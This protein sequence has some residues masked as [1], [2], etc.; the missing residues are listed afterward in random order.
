M[1]DALC[2]AREAEPT[3]PPAHI[4]SAFAADGPLT[5]LAGGRGVA[6]RAGSIVLKPAASSEEALGWQA[7][8]L[9]EISDDHLRLAL[10]RRSVFGTFLFGGWMAAVF[11]IGAHEPRRWLDIIAAG[12]RLHAAL[13]NVACPGFESARHD[14][15]SIADQAA[16]GEIPLS[17]YLDA[18]H[19][20]RLA[21]RLVPVSAP[22]QVIHG[23]LTGNVL[24]ADPLPPAVIDLSLYCRPAA[25]AGAIVVADALAWETATRRELDRV[26]S[27][28]GFGQLLARAVLFRLI[29]DWLVDRSAADLRAPAYAPAVDLAIEAT[30]RDR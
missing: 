17:P 3:K 24:F 21:S 14:P 25:Y 30:A 11:C 13:A 22:S 7:E 20:G 1:A 12:E 15:W 27:S 29:T 10:P 5:P 16:W 18:P 6:W 8:V 23:D 19:V 2:M 28:P 4:L 26:I 9:A